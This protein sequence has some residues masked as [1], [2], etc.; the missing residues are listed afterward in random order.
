MDECME[1]VLT[2]DAKAEF[3][4]QA[5]LAGTH[6]VANFTTL[7]NEM[8]F[9]ISPTYANRD[10]NQYMQKYLRKKPNMKVH[11]F[12]SRLLKLNNYL[13]YFHPDHSGQSFFIKF[14]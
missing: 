3:L 12:T 9:H 5:N 6:T 7:M 10:Q 11:I 2:V 13:A 14:I 8:T 4:H 1:S